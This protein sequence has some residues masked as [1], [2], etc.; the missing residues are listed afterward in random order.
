MTVKDRSH[1]KQ[2][3][4]FLVT[5]LLPSLVLIILTIRMINQEKELAQR[6][7]L[8]ERSRVAREIGN[9]LLI[10]LENVKLQETAN[11][12]NEKYL[13]TKND[14]INPEVELICLLE[15]RQLL[16]PWERNQE[17]EEARRFLNHPEF[18]QKIQQAE[19]EEFVHKNY[20]R[21]SQLYYKILHTFENTLQKNYARLLLGR[22]LL[23]SNQKKKALTQYQEILNLPFIVSD[24]YGIPLSVYA[25]S[26]LL[27]CEMS[28]KDV[29]IHI[30][31][32]LKHIPRLPP[33]ASYRILDILEQLSD[34]PDSTNRTEIDSCKNLI[35]THIHKLDQVM[36]LQK[37]YLSLGLNLSQGNQ[38][39]KKNPLWVI[40]GED[41][42]LVSLAEFGSKR[43]SFLLAVSANKILSSLK[44]DLNFTEIFPVD[45]HFDLQ[46]VPDGFSLG[47]N[48]QGVNIVYGKNQ[49]VMF[50]P[51][52]NV[53]PAFYL[54]ALILILGITLFGAYLLWRDIRRE[55][56]LAEMRS[57]FVSSVSH[58]LKTPLTAIRMFAETLRMGRLK[59]RKLQSEFLDTIVNESQRLT[60]LL[61]N[62]LDFSRIEQGKRIYRFESASLYEIIQS[63][64]LAM[65][66][67]LSQQGFTLQVHSE[68][69]LPEVS[70][71][72][73][74]LEQAILNLLHNAM[75]Y[76]DES[77]NI[78][79]K[80]K[81]KENKALIQVIDQGIGIAS[82]EQ[83]Q[84]FEKFYRIPS[85]DNERIVGTGL[86]LTLVSH[87]VKAHSGHLELESMP[88]KGSTFS[89]YLP[90]ED[91]P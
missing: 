10:K 85:P 74:A 51:L 48:F 17:I 29:L 2:I 14:F 52:W 11:I 61:N 71:D 15:E 66:Y 32:E 56:Q 76:S 63:A 44:S 83:K 68:E 12:K 90:L 79:L 82:N 6:R 64:V 86:G 21:A 60:R 39:E 36:A 35:H 23:K 69:D 67:P 73:D 34:I 53:R 25:A 77:R 65:K 9:Q 75:K 16:L 78:Q 58:E 46:N 33:S 87:I 49:A 57:Q 26:R 89:I 62:V 80:L 3:L 19:K 42:W 28:G 31:I 18:T 24:E 13:P 91:Q 40:Y 7:S 8:E 1:H 41:P 59:N 50:P 30:Q 84:I 27:E 72:R 20:V 54:L 22:T 4:L 88:G 45:F 70:V 55:V 38:S 81:K 43:L 5:V 37:N 47:T